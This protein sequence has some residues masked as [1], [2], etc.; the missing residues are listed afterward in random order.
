[1][2]GRRKKRTISERCA[3]ETPVGLRAGRRKRQISELRAGVGMASK[4]Q[5]HAGLSSHCPPPPR[6]GFWSG[7]FGE[8]APELALRPMVI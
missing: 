3:P 7:K 4:T 6:H 2:A 1:M 5:S 8:G